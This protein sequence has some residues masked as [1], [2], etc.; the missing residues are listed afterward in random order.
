MR[1]PEAPIGCP[2]ATAPPLTLTRSSS[3]PS[4]R[5]ELSVTDANASLISHRSMSPG[6]QAGLLERLLGGARG[7]GGEVGEV[8]GALRV[9]D[10]LR[11]RLL[12][13]G[14]RPT[15]RRTSTSAPAPSLTPGEL[16]AVC[17]P[18]LPTRPGSAA[19]FSSEVSRRGPSSISTTVS[20]LRPLTVTD[21]D[22]LGQA[23]LVGRLQRELVRAQRP[24]VEVG[25]GHLE[26]VADLGGLD[27]HLLAGERVGEPVVDH[28]V[29]HLGVAHAVAEARLRA[30][31][32]AP[33]TSTP[34]RRR[35]RPPCRPRGSP[36]RGSPTRAARRRRP[37]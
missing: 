15:P 1:A 10:D 11:E 36:G 13:V 34:C 30:A 9:G 12:A 4:M 19:S 17:E 28:R 35:R 23:A 14:R 27:E 2:S 37:C 5:I 20:P 26:L 33:S 8:V 29:E 25:A 32:R 31:G 3:M 18:S 21:D 7:R 22:L 24:A 6:L 16:P